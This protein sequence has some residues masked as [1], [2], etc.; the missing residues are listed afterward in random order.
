MEGPVGGSVVR[1]FASILMRFEEGND[2]YL[3]N[4][5]FATD[6]ATGQKAKDIAH[7]AYLENWNKHPKAV[8]K[9]LFHEGVLLEMEFSEFEI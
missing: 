5:Y 7:P 9:H 3:A 6:I 2:T 8:F 1:A 4:C